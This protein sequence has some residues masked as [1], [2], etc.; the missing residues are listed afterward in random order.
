MQYKEPNCFH[1]AKDDSC[2]I[3]G[4]ATSRY[5]CNARKYTAF[6]GHKAYIFHIGKHIC[7]AKPKADTVSNYI[8]NVLKI[9]PTATTAS[10]QSTTVISA[11]TQRKSWNRIMVTTKNVNSCRLISDEKKKQ[12]KTIEPQGCGFDAVISL[13][14]FTDE[15]DP[16]LLYETSENAQYVFKSSSSKM[17]V[18]NLMSKD[19][20]HFLCEEYCYFD[21]KE[22][23]T[24]NF[25]TLTA[26]V[27]HNLLKK[28]IPLATMVCLQKNYRQVEL[29]WRLFK[30]AFKE[31][32][33]TAKIFEPNGW[34]TDMAGSD[35]V[36]LEK[37]YG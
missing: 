27:Y 3:C 30:R 13:K 8:E 17:H 19:S 6:K 5:P 7:A 23:R 16:L 22:G 36:D 9:N 12:R 25:K 18:A 35:F 24:K 37:S 11:I 2:K 32:N 34:V 15:N 31:V 4:A 21:G 10:V 29:F 26:S 14:R 20:G 28:Q 1:L 33:K